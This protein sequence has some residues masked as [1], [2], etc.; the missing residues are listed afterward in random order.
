MPPNFS[1]ID[2]PRLAAMA[3]PDSAEDV[4]WLRRHGIEVLLSLT[5]VPP[6]RE[7]I[8][9]AGLM[10]VHVPVPDM[11]APS[12]RQLDK[13]LD[14]IQQAH[15][16]NLGVAVHC[17]AGRGRTGTVVAAYLVASG[18]SARDAIEKTRSLRPG[19]IESREQ[20]ELIEALARRK[21]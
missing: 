10:L 3:F 15:A 11:T 1:W 21:K 6:P 14:A 13:I 18:L 17:A 16:S 12:A 5:E 19:S 9:D 4:A 8:N 20:E 7:W 2:Q